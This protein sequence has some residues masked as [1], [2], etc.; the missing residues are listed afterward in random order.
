MRR[1]LLLLTIVSPPDFWP[2][3]RR[4]R[5]TRRAVIRRTCAPSDHHSYVW[6]DA[7]GEG[8]HCAK[9]GAA[10]YNS[11]LDTT[12]ITSEGLTD[13]GRAAGTA[14]PARTTPTSPRRRKRRLG[15][16]SDVAQPSLAP[17]ARHPAFTSRG[18]VQNL[19]GHVDPGNP[20]GTASR[21]RPPGGAATAPSIDFLDELATPRPPKLSRQRSR[22]D[23]RHLILMA[24]LGDSFG[25]RQ[26]D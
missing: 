25:D 21:R 11:A 1:L 2:R 19:A 3:G 16:D 10:E 18:P 12:V 14:P 5:R 23:V 24:C 26:M 6:F 9:P 17:R 13:Y 15:A 20:S 22:A 8:W 7:S 4:R